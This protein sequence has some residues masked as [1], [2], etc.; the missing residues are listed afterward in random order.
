MSEI[1]F[2]SEVSIHVVDPSKYFIEEGYR[3]NV[4]E[5]YDDYVNI[6]DVIF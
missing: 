5:K 3:V 6:S 4:K 2:L 1:H